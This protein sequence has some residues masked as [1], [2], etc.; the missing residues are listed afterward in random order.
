MERAWFE[1]RGE[2]RR[3]RA[4]SVWIPLR[5]FIEVKEKEYGQLGYRAE[6]TAVRS[7][8]VH[9]AQRDKVEPLSWNDTHHDHGVYTYD[10]HYKPAEVHQLQTGEDLGIELV[11]DQHFGG[12]EPR[13]GI[14]TKTSPSHFVYYGKETFGFARRKVISRSRA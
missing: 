7:V 4:G 6:V 13:S 10:G 3:A 12:L 5:A 11:L 8:A 9:L 1:M 14:S 2:I